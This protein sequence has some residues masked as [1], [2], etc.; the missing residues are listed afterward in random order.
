MCTT[1]M[2]DVEEAAKEESDDDE[3]GA[4]LRPV[5]LDGL[6]MDAELEDTNAQVASMIY[7]AVLPVPG[8]RVPPEGFKLQP[9]PSFIVERYCATRQGVGKLNHIGRE[10]F[11]IH[12]AALATAP[13]C[14]VVITDVLYVKPQCICQIWLLIET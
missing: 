3:A 11:S 5:A 7:I 9:A 13:A 1:Y 2:E 6:Y 10:H 12:A 4:Q 14:P 8:V